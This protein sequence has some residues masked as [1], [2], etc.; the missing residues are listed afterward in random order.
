MSFKGKNKLESTKELVDERV[1]YKLTA[2]FDGKKPLESNIV[3]FNFSERVHYGRIDVNYNSISPNEDNLSYIDSSFINSKAPRCINFVSDAFF[4]F[5]KKINQ[6]KL[7]N[8]FEKG[9]F[10]ENLK[11][12][13]AY[14]SP[15]DLYES[16]ANEYIAVFNKR[17]KKDKITKYETW[18]DELVKWHA[19][20][21]ANFPLTFSGF[22]KSK[23]SNIFTSGLA[24]SFSN[25]SAGDDTKKEKLVLNDKQ[26]EFYLNAAKQYGFSVHQNTP[27]VIIA[28]LNSPAMALY[29]KKYDLSTEKD[30]FFKNYDLCY[31]QDIELLTDLLEFNW[32][33]YYSKNK[34]IT[35]L[36]TKCNKT[37]V[38]NI[39]INNNININ[40]IYYI[41]NYINIRNTEEYGR[42]S[43]SELDRITKKAIF[44][45]KKLD[46]SKAIGYINE[47]FRVLSLKRSGTLNDKI[48]IN[49]R[50]NDISNN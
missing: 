19:Q 29:T 35:L 37:K 16:F 9:S 38:S 27:W 3:D 26:L 43:K 28:D 1:K 15:L 24:I 41:I 47:Q 42:Y 6:A 44:F 39:Y 23:R 5:M 32:L 33:E 36:D 17:V 2:L 13:K 7:M 25:E 14:E 30:I 20:N 10:F 12:H 34:K 45:Q 22:Q 31:K 21:G 8:K 49:R 46:K 48:N 11:V 4:A 50:A 40:N 18:I